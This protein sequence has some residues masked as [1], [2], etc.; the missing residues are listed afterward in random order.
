[1]PS[2][3][4]TPSPNANRASRPPWTLATT[5]AEAAEFDDE[6]L[7]A[8]DEDDEEE[9]EEEEE[10]SVLSVDEPRELSLVSV[11]EEPDEVEDGDPD[12][13]AEGLA[14]LELELLL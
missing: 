2:Y 3:K 12:E 13:V 9:E 8:P 7:D 11:A 6:V 5:L 1:M 4:A 14:G 10:P